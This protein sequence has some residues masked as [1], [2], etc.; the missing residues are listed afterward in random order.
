MLKSDVCMLAS[1]DKV[2]KLNHRK[3]VKVVYKLEYIAEHAYAPKD[4]DIV[5]WCL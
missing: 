5:E 2:L 3:S 4:S 1:K